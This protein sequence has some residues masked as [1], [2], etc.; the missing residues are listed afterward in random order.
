FA[1]LTVAGALPWCAALAV[2]GYQVGANYDRVSGPIEKGA[3]AIAV[4]VAAG[5]IAWIV[6]GRGA[7]RPAD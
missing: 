1:V 6:R 7:T 2:A 4:L 5:V 3:V